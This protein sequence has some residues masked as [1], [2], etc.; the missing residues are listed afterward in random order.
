MT[1][2]QHAYDPDLPY[3]VEHASHVFARFPSEEWAEAFIEPRRYG[4]DYKIIDT[5]PAPRVPEDAEH[6]V[7]I[8]AATPNYRMYAEKKNGLWFHEDARNGCALEDLPGVTPETTFT[9]LDERKSD[10]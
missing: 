4:S 1:D 9:V 6:V 3:V 7:W 8:F 2:K 10:A 5:T